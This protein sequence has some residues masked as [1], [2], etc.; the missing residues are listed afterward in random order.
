MTHYGH[1]FW[2]G[3]YRNNFSLRCREMLEAFCG[4]LWSVKEMQ[5]LD[6]TPVKQVLYSAVFQYLPYISSNTCASEMPLTLIVPCQTR[7]LCSSCCRT[8]LPRNDPWQNAPAH[9]S[10][11]YHMQLDAS[12]LK[13]RSW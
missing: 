3:C 9:G 6:G 2:L 8:G 5:A 4:D 12:M 1:P 11:A 13:L 10:W 7:P